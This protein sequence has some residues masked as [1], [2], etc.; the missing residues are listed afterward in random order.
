MKMYNDEFWKNVE[1]FVKNC[2]KN[3]DVTHGFNHVERVLRHLKKLCRGRDVDWNLMKLSCLLHDTGYSRD[4][5]N[6]AEASCT[7]AREFLSSIKFDEAKKEKAIEIIRNHHGS[8]SSQSR[9]FEGK[10]LWT[11]D[12]LDWTSPYGL[13][14]AVIQ[15]A[16]MNSFDEMFKFYIDSV[17]KLEIDKIDDEKLK[18]VLNKNWRITEKILERLV[19]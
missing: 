11:A 8:W 6:H 5:K 9:C 1:D 17:K 16:N 14:R 10:L 7:I 15:N 13:M 18:E 3:Q 19:G 2:L 12:K 4:F